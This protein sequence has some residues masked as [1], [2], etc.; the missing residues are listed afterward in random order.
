MGKKRAAPK[1]DPDET[2]VATTK[3]KASHSDRLKR[4]LAS[5]ETECASLRAQGRAAAARSLKRC[6]KTFSGRGILVLA[7]VAFFCL[8]PTY[9]HMHRKLYHKHSC[10]M[11]DI[12]TSISKSVDGDQAKLADL[13]HRCETATKRLNAFI[14]ETNAQVAEFAAAQQEMA[15]AQRS[16]YLRFCKSVF[17]SHQMVFSEESARVNVLTQFI[18][19]LCRICLRIWTPLSMLC[20]R[21]PLKASETMTVAQILITNMMSKVKTTFIGLIQEVLINKNGWASISS[22]VGGL[23]PK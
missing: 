4:L 8:N 13:V 15:Q 10:N 17:A 11:H 16:D 9:W 21:L 18:L 12:E 1:E 23:L 6:E 14:D 22:S 7:L 20:G 5:V 3:P 2:L 19:M